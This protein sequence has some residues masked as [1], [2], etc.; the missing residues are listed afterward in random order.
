MDTPEVEAHAHHRTGISWLDA[1]LALS[2]F[3]VSTISLFVAIHH[4][5]T[6]KEMAEA[7][8]KM[9]E[10]TVWPFVEYSSGNSANGEQVISMSLVNQGVGPARIKKFQ[11]LYHDKPMKSTEDLLK[12]CCIS[13]AKDEA[14]LRDFKSGALSAQAEG[15]ILPAHGGDILFLG[16][17]RTEKNAAVWDRLNS[18]RF[19]MQFQVCFCSVFNECWTSLRT[20]SDA[21]PVK[22]CPGDWVSFAE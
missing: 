19:K 5:N 15:R 18:E 20:G 22:E 1:S 10:A 11:I 16:L 13:R 3:A 6:M 2:A 4:G 7:N 9:V 21:T 12:A 17:R 8:A 14:S